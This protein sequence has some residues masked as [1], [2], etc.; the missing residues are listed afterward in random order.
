MHVLYSTI[1]LPFV[2]LIIRLLLVFGRMLELTCCVLCTVCNYYNS[3][4]FLLE[5][6]GTICCN[7][8]R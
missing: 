6:C 1:W 8:L 2:L 4:S 7:K 3:I 5:K